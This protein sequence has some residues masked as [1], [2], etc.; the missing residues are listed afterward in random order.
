MFP[1]TPYSPCYYLIEAYVPVALTVTRKK[2]NCEINAL[3]DEVE[4]IS[5]VRK[6]FYKVMAA[7]V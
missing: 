6:R 7:T 5:E 2:Y 3:V 4:G 1:E